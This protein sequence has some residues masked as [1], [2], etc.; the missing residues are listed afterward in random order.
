MDT[1]SHA[2]LRNSNAYGNH[3]SVEP[4]TKIPVQ[5]YQ[6]VDMR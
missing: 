1:L 4:P 6:V 3:Y 2:S 5:I